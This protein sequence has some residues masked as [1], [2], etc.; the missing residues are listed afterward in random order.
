MVAVCSVAAVVNVIIVT[1]VA[2]VIAAVIV[3]AVVVVVWGS[4]YQIVS[5]S[6]G[7]NCAS[8]D[9][10]RGSKNLLFC[11]GIEFGATQRQG[12]YT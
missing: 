10:Y 4:L 2:V 3:V 1:V 12:N 7:L 8:G 5:R 11:A 9:G 6:W